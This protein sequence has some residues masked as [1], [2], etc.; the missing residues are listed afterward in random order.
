MRRQPNLRHLVR[1]RSFQQLRAVSAEWMERH[2]ELIEA[3]APGLERI[4]TEVRDRCRGSAHWRGFELG[5]PATAGR[6]R[7]LTVVY[8]LDGPLLAM[9]DV[10][11]EGLFTAGWGSSRMSEGARPAARQLW[12]ALTGQF[13]HRGGSENVIASPA[14]HRLSRGPAL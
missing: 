1:R 3:S 5:F 6:G 12:V 13:A 2:V 9:I 14:R 10:L 11:G 4:G 7:S 8:G